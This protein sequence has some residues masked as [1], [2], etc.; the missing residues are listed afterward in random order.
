LTDANVELLLNT[1]V[2]SYKK[3]IELDIFQ[4]PSVFFHRQAINAKTKKKKYEMI[5]ALLPAWGMHRMGMKGPKVGEHDAAIKNLKKVDRKIDSLKRID[6]NRV[7]DDDTIKDAFFGLYV[8]RNDRVLIGNSKILH[9]L[10]PGKL[11]I[12]DKQYTLS[13]VERKSVPED[14]EKQFEIYKWIHENIYYPILNDDRFKEFYRT[15]TKG[16][17]DTSKIKIIDNLIIGYEK[18]RE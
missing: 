18:N 3:F 2:E 13:F 16:F 8:M 15:L 9:H 10:L 7:F 14:I 1:L 5:Y 6:I 17:W 11:G 4:G 12:I